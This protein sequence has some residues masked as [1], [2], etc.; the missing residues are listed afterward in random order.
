MIEYYFI[1]KLTPG[2]AF[3][4]GMITSTAIRLIGVY[5]L[6]RIKNK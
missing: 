3:L 4:L 1:S 5:I 6:K 2:W